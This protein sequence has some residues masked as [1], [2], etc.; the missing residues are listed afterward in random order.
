ML[1]AN[2]PADGYVVE[3]GSWFGKSAS[4]ML[5]R[6]PN[7][8]LV[9]IDHWQGGKDIP[10]TN[11]HLIPLSEAAFLHFCWMFQDRVVPIRELTIEGMKIVHEAGLQPALVYVDAAHDFESVYQDIITAWE[12][13]PDAILVGD[14][15]RTA[16]VA[17]AV[18]KAAAGFSVVVDH[19]TNA[20]CLQRRMKDENPCQS[21][22]GRRPRS[23]KIPKDAKARL[24]GVDRTG[25][26]A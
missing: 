21:D 20:W 24:P 26:G 2:L 13:F 8:K 1:A 15:W 12:L 19:N 4:T 10:K 18:Q 23:E 7:V 6:R 17:A 3:L 5:T 22:S 9:C 14:D 16:S 25:P 11:E